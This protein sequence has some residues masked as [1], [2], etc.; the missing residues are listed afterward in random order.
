MGTLAAAA[1]LAA[2][3]FTWQSIQQVNTEQTITREG[4]ITDRYN[5]AVENLGHNSVEVRLD[6]IY[7]LQRIMHDSHRDQPVVISVLAT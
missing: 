1:T 6:G 3:A 2:V 7:A 4:Q 5:A